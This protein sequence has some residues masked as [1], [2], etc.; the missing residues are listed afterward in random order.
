VSEGTRIDFQVEVNSYLYGT[1]FMTWLPRRSSP[2]PGIHWVWRREGSRAYYSSAFRHVFGVTLEQAWAAWVE[3][4]QAF[5]QNNLEL[6][7]KF[8][9][10]TGQDLTTRALGSVSRA[11]YDPE[12]RKIYAGLNYPGALSHIG[13]ISLSSGN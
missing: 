2:A 6:I 7:R 3:D 8:P 1:R 10:T 12:A 13:A 11:Y 5:Q 9:T 4:E